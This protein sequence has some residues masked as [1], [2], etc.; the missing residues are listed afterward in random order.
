[1]TGWLGLLSLGLLLGVRHALDPDHVI[2]VGTITARTP[3]LRRSVGIGA[4]WGLGHTLTILFVGGA[5]VIF[6]AAISPRA[7]LP[8]S[9]GRGRQG[10]S[11][12]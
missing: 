3:S 9:L 8:R 6:R 2:A 5:L 7:G 4:L 1:M 11:S 10:V 12:T